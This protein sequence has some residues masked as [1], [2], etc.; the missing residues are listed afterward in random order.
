M[1]ACE[2][3]ELIEAGVKDLF[4]RLDRLDERIVNLD[5]RL[6]DYRNKQ[7]F[8]DLKLTKIEELLM[9]IAGRLT[10]VEDQLRT[11]RSG[12]GKTSR[13]VRPPRR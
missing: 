2:L 3:T 12:N 1:Y 8:A 4:A 10:A 13:R 11:L 7:V 5:G 6:A 9:N